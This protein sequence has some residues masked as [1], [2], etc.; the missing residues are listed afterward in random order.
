MSPTSLS[1]KSLVAP[2]RRPP[3]ELSRTSASITAKHKYADASR[4]YMIYEEGVYGGVNDKLV[5]LKH[6]CM[7]EGMD[8]I[9]GD[10]GSEVAV[11]EAIDDWAGLVLWYGQ[12]LSWWQM[13]GAGRG[14]R[15]L[16]HRW[17]YVNIPICPPS[18]V[19]DVSAIA[20]HIFE[21][22]CSRG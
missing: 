22:D 15:A 5:K 12:Y 3:R 8:C 7:G 11:P 1:T 17:Y 16:R 18:T 4:L 13:V 20:C 14:N 2:H 21:L 6:G 10:E 9:E 19:E